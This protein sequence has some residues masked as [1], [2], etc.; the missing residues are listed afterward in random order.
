MHVQTRWYRSP[1]VILLQPKY[2]QLVDVWSIG[3]LVGELAFLLDPKTQQK[4]F[5]RGNSCN[6]L[7]PFDKRETKTGEN[8][9]SEN[10]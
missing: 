7:S 1:E 2:N 3:C 9:I 8:N 6:P 5:F 10:D 4:T